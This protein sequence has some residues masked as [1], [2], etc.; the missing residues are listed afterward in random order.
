MRGATRERIDVL[1]SAL[2]QCP[3]HLSD[4]VSKYRHG[5]PALSQWIANTRASGLRVAV[6]VMIERFGDIVACLPV[7]HHLKQTRPNI[8]IAWVCAKRF[9]SLAECN[10]SVDR[11]FH[12]ESISSWLL[13]KRLLPRDVDCY[14]LFLDTQRCTW[15]GIKAQKRKSGVTLANYLS[16]GS[17]LLLAYSRAAGLWDVPDIQPELHLPELDTYWRM[18]IEGK[19]V[20]AVHFDSEDPDRRL[21][22]ESATA[23][24]DKALACGWTIVELGLRPIVSERNPTV[25]FP[26]RTLSLIQ[27]IALLGASDHFSGGFSGF[28]VCANA[29]SKPA[30]VFIGTFRNFSKITPVSGEFWRE[31]WD[32]VYGPWQASN[33]PVLVADKHVPLPTASMQ[34]QNR[35]ATC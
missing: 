4:L 12:D 3:A 26:G 8:A 5:N 29:L 18:R 21:R 35:N 32:C 23:F 31:N 2:R 25:L 20:M 16:D 33:C 19:P 15:T 17:H 22:I 24:I 6:V 34:F 10:P 13:T 28:M 9:S 14:E 30:T 27:Q 1:A 11:V 7:A